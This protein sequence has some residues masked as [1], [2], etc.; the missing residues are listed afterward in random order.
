M[1]EGL[2]L[3]K[4]QATLIQLQ[5]QVSQE[6]A[7]LRSH[8]STELAKSIAGARPRSLAIRVNYRRG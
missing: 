3:G 6:D 8:L 5:V 2:L 4:G 1:E 7:S